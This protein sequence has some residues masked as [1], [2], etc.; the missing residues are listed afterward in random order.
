MWLETWLS[1][2]V[3]FD[4]RIYKEYPLYVCVIV[5]SFLCSRLFSRGLVLDV[6]FYAPDP[7]ARLTDASGCRL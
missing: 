2:H 7:G 3:I 1:S 6:S 5:R 4:G